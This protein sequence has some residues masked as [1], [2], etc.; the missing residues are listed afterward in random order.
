[1]ARTKIVAT[2]GPSCRDLGTL[3]AMI[4]AGMD[5][6]RI[7][8][9][10]S[11]H[12]FIQDLVTDIRE[13]STRLDKPVGILLDLSGP[14]LRT[15]KLEKG[16][17]ELVK[18]SQFTLTS[19]KVP[20]DE[21]C[22]TTNY[23]PLAREVHEG[24]CILLDDGLM[25]LKVLSTTDTDCVCEIVTGGVLKNN[26]GINI[27]GIRLSIPALTEKDKKDLAFGL[28]CEVDF[29]A[30]SFVRDAQDLLELR[31][32]M[33]DHWPTPM[34]IA[35]L[36][37]PEAV[38]HL[39]EILNVTDAVMIARGDLGVELPPEQV[40]PAQKLIT[41]KAVAKGKPVITATQMLDSMVNNPRPT[42]AEA[43]D[44]ANAI[45]DGTDAVMLSEETATG[46][47]PLHA[48]R[49]M[50]RI[51]T[52]VET[53]QEH[54]NQLREGDY[55][56]NPAYAIAHA[57]C[58]MAVDMKAK[59][60][61]TFTK[62]GATARLISQQRPPVSIVALTQHGHVYN[63]LTLLWGT[64]PVMLTEVSDSI[65][66]LNM[67]EQTLLCRG[68]VAAKDNIVITGGLPLAAR[69]PANFVK[70]STISP[71]LPTSDW[72]LKGI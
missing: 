43:S 53:S 57:A 54:S 49:M 32:L 59:V 39:D 50:E 27:P 24:A 35:K 45:F 13:L 40:P 16:S 19:R 31:E 34:V 29:V 15:G 28:K 18:G 38:E 7:N 33:A 46:K 44:V 4:E 63:Q 11:E 66:T 9:S 25:E 22:V 47:Y 69:G 5:V 8:C 3:Q 60:I 26:Q 37:K 65:S 36:E 71:R 58:E 2:I 20:G 64:T 62:S 21:S 14:K 56:Q 68:M 17:I 70:L 42:R 51:A 72:E 12:Q 55:I 23:E 30:L 48:I 10:H 67:V 1:M 6:A 52:T 41:R 61:A